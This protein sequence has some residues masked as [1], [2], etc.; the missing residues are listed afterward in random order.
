MMRIV[1]TRRIGGSAQPCVFLGAVHDLFN[2]DTARY[3]DFFNQ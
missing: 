3:Q 1:R 2:F